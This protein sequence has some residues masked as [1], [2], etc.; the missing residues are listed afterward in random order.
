M[1]SRDF[2]LKADHIDRWEPSANR[3][4]GRIYL[5]TDAN[6]L[7]AGAIFA[8]VLKPNEMPLL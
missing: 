3:F 1:G 6:I 4:T 8:G 7:S 2:Q 5:V